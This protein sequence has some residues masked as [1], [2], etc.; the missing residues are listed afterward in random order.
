LA[1]AW[2]ALTAKVRTLDER[3][4]DPRD[5]GVV[6][7]SWGAAK[8]VGLV[9]TAPVVM[10]L[11]AATAAART[12]RAHVAAIAFDEGVSAS[13]VADPERPRALFGR[14]AAASAGERW[15]ITSDL[16]RGFPG[17][18]DWPGRQGTTAIYESMLDHYGA[19]GWGLIE[20]GDVEDFWLTGGSTYGALYDV[21][22]LAGAV[23]GP[24][25]DG[26]RRVVYGEHLDAIVDHN[27]GVYERI[28]RWF[29]LTGRYR[30]VIGNHDDVYADPAIV[31]RL[32]SHHPGLDVVDAVALVDDDRL[33]G[34][35]AH[36]HQ[37]DP[38]NAPGSATLGQLMT[39]WH[40]ALSDA[41]LVS[42]PGEPGRGPAELLRT[43]RA[44]NVLTRVTSPLGLTADLFTVDEVDLFD[45]FR[46]RWPGGGAATDQEPLLVLGHTHAPRA[47]SAAPD[48]SGIWAGYVNGGSG[49]EHE[50]V[51]AVEWDG[52][53]DPARP[54]V[55]LV[56]WSLAPHSHEAVRVELHA[57]PSG[58]LTPSDAVG[59]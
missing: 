31:E 44:P 12:A 3:R 1:A 58:R 55:R 54:V 15:L 52:S 23:A 28:N 24:V 5:R 18:S 33:V 32:R 19:E 47:G 49:V 51:T 11:V 45:A 46:R 38:W 37:T 2:S 53:T 4:G 56:A 13:V 9:A 35:V 39:W 59:T 27:P 22:R 26:W 10:P 41:P 57:G 48:G 14:V 36:G 21:A 25:G 17:R 8:A 34:L 43:G 20:N 40:S 42:S 16:H 29:H 6:A 50:T 7:A 30:R